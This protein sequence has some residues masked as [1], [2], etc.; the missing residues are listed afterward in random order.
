MAVENVDGRTR[1]IGVAVAMAI[2]LAVSGLLLGAIL[3]EGAVMVLGTLALDPSTGT[4][5]VLSAVL[6]QGLAF[7]GTAAVYLRLRGLGLAYLSPAVPDLRG[8]LWAVSGYIL[9]LLGAIAVGILAML[10]GLEPAQNRISEIGQGNPEI[11]LLLVPV[12]FLLIGPG[13]ELLFRGMVQGTLREVFGPVLAI[14]LASGVFAAA[15]VTSLSGALSGRAV[16]IGLLVVPAI[17][18]GVVYECTGNI[19]VPAVVHGAYNATLFVLGYIAI[20][21]DGTT[22]LLTIV[23]M[24][25][26]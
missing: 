24:V 25:A 18:L 17:V 22:A 1:R 13:E 4:R 2:V 6:L 14:G 21:F 12:S 19:V 8:V 20:K 3:V 15:H 16:T 9:A 26:A 23:T 7:G 10:A 5:V 11:F